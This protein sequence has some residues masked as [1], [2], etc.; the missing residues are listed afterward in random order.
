MKRKVLFMMVVLSVCLTS[1]NAGTVAYWRFEEG[2]AGAQVPKPAPTGFNWY[3]SVPDSSGNGNELT[4]WDEGGAGYVFRD[5]VA[6]STV[7]PLGLTN[8]FS[9]KNSGGGPAMWT[10]AADTISSITP[11]AF[12]IEATFKLENDGH[13]T[14]VGRDARGITTDGSNSDN[15]ALYFQAVPDNGLAI[16]FVD[17]AGYFHEAVAPANSY[18][19][20]DWGT[21]PDGTSAPWYSMAAVSDGSTLSLYL[22]QHGAGTGWQLIAQTDM[23]TVNPSPNTALNNGSGGVAGTGDWTAGNF[24]VGRGLWA[25]GHGDRAYGYLDEIRISDSALSVDEFLV[26]E[27]ATLALL[28]LGAL[29]LRRKK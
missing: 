29:V 22:I 19:G 23:T 10:D 16:K 20:Y 15:A 6:Y 5:D 9:V 26:P 11:A 28:G 3:P 25:G 21:D 4:V 7:E 17:V 8:N 27:P 12:T 1:L 14:I 13:K 2:P 24:S 18:I